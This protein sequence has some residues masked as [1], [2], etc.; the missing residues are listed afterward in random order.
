MRIL[1]V[2]DERDLNAILVKKLKA[3]G[4][5][6][7][8]C[9]DGEEALEYISS[10]EYDAIIL[11]IMMPKK[12]GMEV[13]GTLRAKGDLVPVLFL[14]ARDAVED[15]VRG[16]DMGANDYLIKP[17]SLEELMA[18][19]RAMTRKADNHPT[20]VYTAADLTVDCGTH[21]VYR[22]DTAIALS[23]REFSMLEYLIRNQGIV[24]SRE[25]IETHIWNY[26]YAGGSNVVDVYI[27]NLRRKI[28]DEYS[29]KLI[30]TV[31]GIG[32]VLREE[33]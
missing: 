3:E 33:P 21:T 7:D 23:T 28:D 22:G 14:T 31:R 30:Q 6:V 9:Y 10:A 4:Y 29:P 18:R 27:R 8:S 1:V 19:I 20:N 25:R 2:E 5:G 24:L 26:D 12:N 32:Y 11:D 17:F 13:L 15:R 16:L